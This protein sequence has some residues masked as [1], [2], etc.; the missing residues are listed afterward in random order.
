VQ[1]IFIPPT[2]PPGTYTFSVGAFRGVD[3]LE[4]TPAKLTD[5]KKRLRVGTFVV[6]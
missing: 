6:K 4:V 5:G 2:T 3:R 1:Q